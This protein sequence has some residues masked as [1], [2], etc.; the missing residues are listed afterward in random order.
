[1]KH[2]TTIRQLPIFN[3]NQKPL[4]IPVSHNGKKPAQQADV[5]KIQSKV[6]ET[7][8]N[9]GELP[10]RQ[11]SRSGNAPTLD[12]RGCIGEPIQVLTGKTYYRNDP[13]K[14]DFNFL[15]GWLSFQFIGYGKSDKTFH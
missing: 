10:L 5:S 2:T 14:Y 3:Y 11:V 12:H 9:A 4:P 6:T 13:V 1:M 7:I 8:L 15:V